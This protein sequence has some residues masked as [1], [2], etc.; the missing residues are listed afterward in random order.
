MTKNSI[1]LLIN[2]S[3]MSSGSQLAYLGNLTRGKYLG[4]FF[5]KNIPRLCSG[6]FFKG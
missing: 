1:K 2:K 6:G 5:W 4:E 3:P